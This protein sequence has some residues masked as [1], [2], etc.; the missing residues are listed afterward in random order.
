MHIGI[1]LFKRV[2]IATDFSVHAQEALNAVS[3]LP[4]VRSVLVV[5]VI[6]HDG[7]ERAWISGHLLRSGAEIGAEKLAAITERYVA[8]G[9]D[10]DY[11]VI[12]Q[13]EGDIASKILD[14]AGKYGAT[15]I[16]VGAHGHGMIGSLFLGNVSAGVL[17]RA[18]IHVI[19]VR[20]EHVEPPLFR[21]V[22][23]PVDF[24]KPSAE[25]TALLADLGAERVALVHVLP[26]HPDEASALEAEQKL[27]ALSET[28]AARGIRAETRVLRG[29]P[30]SAIIRAAQ[31]LE[32]DLILIPRLGRTD[33]MSSISI[34]STARVVGEGAPCTVLILS[35]V[36]SLGIET[37][38]LESSEFPLV[39]AV[40][41]KYH[42]QHADPTTDRIFGVFVEG[43]LA[44][45]ARCRRHPD[46]FEVDGVFTSP[47]FR[48]RGYARHAVEALLDACG[49]DDLYMHSTLELVVFYGH[50]GF[51]AIPESALPKTIRERYSFA[52]GNME[53][54][55]VQPMMRKGK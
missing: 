4:G 54:S 33:Y 7:S 8:A 9:I 13:G 18:D 53:G 23:C 24:G 34:G 38:E 15:A 41:E 43:T 32:A 5:H 35:L 25:A 30:S 17:E 20:D 21:T 2:V 42:G 10:A 6:P 27:S 12:E 29:K 48:G 55:N 19:I 46:G 28:V 50:Y 49:T 37:R 31:D 16:V 22:I 3:L 51:V 36:F 26:D 52:L 11:R 40:W 47:G 14:V 45:V 1:E 44:A 39:D